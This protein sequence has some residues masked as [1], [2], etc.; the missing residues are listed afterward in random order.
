VNKA[1]GSYFGNPA[2][3]RRDHGTIWRSQRGEHKPV[4]PRGVSFTIILVLS[5]GMWWGVWLA[6]SALA[7]AVLA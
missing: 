3:Y 2:K 6:I 4:L 7:S 1:I 5:L